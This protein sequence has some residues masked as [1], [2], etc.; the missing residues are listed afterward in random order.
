M[1][2]MNLDN[3][4]A[5]KLTNIF[6]KYKNYFYIEVKKKLEKIEGQIDQLEDNNIKQ[7]SKEVLSLIFSDS[8]WNYNF[9]KT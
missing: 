9:L 2:K 7:L 1:E 8:Y 6:R 5:S 3:K 4:Q